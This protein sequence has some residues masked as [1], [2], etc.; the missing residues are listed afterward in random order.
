M[1]QSNLRHFSELQDIDGLVEVGGPW[2]NTDNHLDGALA[3]KEVPEQVGD[4]GV[5]VRHAASFAVFLVFPQL[6][7]AGAQSHQ[8]VVDVSGLAKPV[9]GVTRP[10]KIQY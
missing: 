10:R 8:R 1:T 6:F 7:D 9:S 3:L 2:V 5:A 4:L